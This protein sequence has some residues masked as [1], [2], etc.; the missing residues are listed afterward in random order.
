M[1]WASCVHAQDTLIDEFAD[2]IAESLAPRWAGPRVP[3]PD[4]R[5]RP[6]SA[7]VLRSRWAPVAVHPSPATRPE[8]AERA[9]M[10]L[11]DAHEWLAA[12]RWPLPVSDGG[13]GGTTEFDLYLDD[14]AGGL[15]EPVIELGIDAPR[16]WEGL[17]GA[18][19]FAI[20]RDAE[21]FEPAVISAYVQAT[22]LSEDPAEAP[23]W[24]A[25]TGDFVA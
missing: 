3:W 18:S 25:A 1:A 19:V 2:A 9:L 12:R 16:T 7:G 21:R 14:T 20:V 15:G 8:R 23:A 10:A 6:P 22:L 13:Y 17:D 11:E 24:R 4:P 5:P